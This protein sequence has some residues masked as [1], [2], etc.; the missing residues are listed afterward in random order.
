MS[1]CLDLQ[2]CLIENGTGASVEMLGSGGM[3]GGG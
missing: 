3:P 2:E 1:V